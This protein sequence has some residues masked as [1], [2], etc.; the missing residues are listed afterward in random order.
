MGG[1]PTY[2]GTYIGRL[3]LF[4]NSSES[5]QHRCSARHGCSALARPC[6][7]KAPAQFT[8]AAEQAAG[9]TCARLLEGPAKPHSPRA[10]PRH[11]RLRLQAQ[12]HP[13]HEEGA[14]R[15]VKRTCRQNVRLPGDPIPDSPSASSTRFTV[16]SLPLTLLINRLCPLLKSLVSVVPGFEPQ[17]PI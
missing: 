3:R 6:G 5:A 16:Y 8:P 10:L 13:T 15:L 12:R 17:S 4:T 14:P 7:A 2:I 1:G 11:R 9:S